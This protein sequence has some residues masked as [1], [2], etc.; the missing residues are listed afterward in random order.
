MG[1]GYWWISFSCCGISEYVS[2]NFRNCRSYKIPS[3]KSASTSQSFS[4]FSLA[5]F[6]NKASAS[7]LPFL[8]SLK[9]INC[10]GIP[11]LIS[12]TLTVE[13]LLPF[14]FN[15]VSC[16]SPNVIEPS[17]QGFIFISFLYFIYE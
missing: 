2:R 5:I 12:I 11:S 16:S 15:C 6:M 8:L 4:P 17:L 1:S 7:L 9:E 13:T 10:C 3:S 14:S